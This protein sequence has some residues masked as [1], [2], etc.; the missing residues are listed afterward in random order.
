MSKKRVLMADDEP[1]VLRVLRLQLEKAGYEVE[2]VPNGEAALE[3]IRESHPDVL[4]TDIEMPRMSGEELCIA[5]QDEFPDR[6]FPIFVAT[7]LTGLRHREW[8]KK[9]DDLHFLEKPLSARKMLT[10]LGDYFAGLTNRNT[11][12]PASC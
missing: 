12:E 2:T 10:A 3:R 1:M 4:I 8:A 6:G 7:S 9:I 5:L 11:Q